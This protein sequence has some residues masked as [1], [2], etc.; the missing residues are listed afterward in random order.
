MTVS[1]SSGK[2]APSRIS[3]LVVDDHPIVRAGL[4]DLIADQPDL[5]IVAE[6]ENGERAVAR[7]REVR[8]D[9]TLMDLR[10][11]VMGGAEAITRI[12]AEFPEARIIALTTYDG[13]ADIRRALHAGA[14]GYL[15]KDM[16]PTEV[17]AAIRA[18]SR[19]ERAIPVA[20]AV[21]LAEHPELDG[22]TPRELEVLE[23]MARGLGNKKIAEA[24][25]RTDET[26]KLHV[27]N[28]FRKLNVDSRTAAVSVGLVRGLVHLP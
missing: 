10:M 25:G 18:V 26:V 11:P 15:L 1:T 20:V 17:V 8:P 3:L 12:R 13:D 21:R 14:R 9:V 22:L 24:I 27:K 2:G 19:G 28:I 4:R 6:A 16:L 5:V 7:F 23:H